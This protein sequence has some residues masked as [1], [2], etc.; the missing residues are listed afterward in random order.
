MVDRG[1][2]AEQQAQMLGRLHALQQ[3]PGNNGAGSATGVLVAAAAAGD[4]EL[5]S[6][7]LCAAFTPP[8]QLLLQP[9]ARGRAALMAA[10]FGRG[11]CPA[12]A[13]PSTTGA[14]SSRPWRTASAKANRAAAGTGGWAYGS[15]KAAVTPFPCRAATAVY[16]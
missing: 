3:R 6:L 14:V 7:L 2:A 12:A 8:D 9:N 10:A 16:W 1:H 13:Q 5:L 15:R 4:T 11:Q